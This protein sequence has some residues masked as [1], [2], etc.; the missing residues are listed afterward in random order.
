MLACI[1]IFAS[2]L[3]PNIAP[4]TADDGTLAGTEQQRSAP[5][6]CVEGT[7]SECGRGGASHGQL[8]IRP[9]EHREA[10]FGEQI[11]CEQ[12]EVRGLHPRQRCRYNS[13]TA[14]A[15]RMLP[16]SNALAYSGWRFAPNGAPPRANSSDRVRLR[17][18]R[19]NGAIPL[20][21]FFEGPVPVSF[22]PGRNL[23]R[24]VE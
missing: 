6:R 13:C 15:S 1:R 16:L 14:R 11:L 2:R 21:P 12:I 23:Q 5:Y 7:A 24:L 22:Q 19:C 8:R 20:Q 4:E 9:T 17:H 3:E 10:A 18:I